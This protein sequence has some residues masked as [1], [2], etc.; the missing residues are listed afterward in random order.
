[1]HL[2][3]APRSATPKAWRRI[4][5]DTATGEIGRGA[6]DRPDDPTEREDFDPDETPPRPMPAVRNEEWNAKK[7]RVTRGDRGSQATEAA[8][9]QPKAS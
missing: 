7:G 3:L 1:M 9:E 8:A 4:F 5:P 2:N 6:A